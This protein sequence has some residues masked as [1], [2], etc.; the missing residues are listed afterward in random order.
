VGRID[1]LVQGTLR[2]NLNLNPVKGPRELAAPAARLAHTP[3]QR[4]HVQSE[5]HLLAKVAEAEGVVL[6]VAVSE[7]APSPPP[8]PKNA[9]TFDPAKP[10]ATVR[11]EPGVDCVQGKHYFSATREWVRQAPEHAWYF[12]PPPAKKEARD[13]YAEAAREVRRLPSLTEVPRAP[14]V[15]IEAERENAKAAAAEALA[16]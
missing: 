11:G 16:E 3:G 1:R 15:V 4:R 13:V 9:A 7:E 8:K 5:D 6:P 2:G 10:F 14:R 12:P